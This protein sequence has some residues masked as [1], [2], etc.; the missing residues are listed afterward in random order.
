MIAGYHRA[1][2]SHGFEYRYAETF[3]GGRIDEC[4]RA[5]FIECPVF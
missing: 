2:A 3:M 5:F 1:T 4:P